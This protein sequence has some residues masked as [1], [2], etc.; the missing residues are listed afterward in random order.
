MK[1]LQFYIK[2]SFPSYVVIKTIIAVYNLLLVLDGTATIGNA[3]WA[4]PSVHVHPTAS[5]TTSIATYATPV[6]PFPTTRTALPIPISVPIPVVCLLLGVLAWQLEGMLPAGKRKS[7]ESAKQLEI[8]L[9][10]ALLSSI[11]FFFS[12]FCCLST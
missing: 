11:F 10:Y 12:F 2:E 4:G 7:L 3:P 6:A 1:L 8:E 5:D 9:Q